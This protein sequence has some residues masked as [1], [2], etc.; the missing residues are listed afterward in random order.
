[1]THTEDQAAARDGD[2]RM[3]ADVV[4]EALMLQDR[5]Y[6]RH[7]RKLS[8]GVAMQSEPLVTALLKTGLFATNIQ[9]MVTLARGRDVP[10]GKV[11]F[12]QVPS[13]LLGMGAHYAVS[14]APKMSGSQ[15][16][17][18]VDVGALIASTEK[19][20]EVMGDIPVDRRLVE[21]VCKTARLR[22][23]IEGPANLSAGD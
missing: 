23:Q 3:R 19:L 17:T 20:E 4:F 14:V 18:I 6:E 21:E 15:D 16:E 1:M 10:A 12:D 2:L 7:G 8:A 5:S 9:S 22:L 13:F 11:E